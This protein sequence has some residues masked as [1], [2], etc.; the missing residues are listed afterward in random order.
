MERFTK[1]QVYEQKERFE[2]FIQRA[3][4][5]KIGKRYMYFIAND[6]ADGRYTP[7]VYLLRV[8]SI[9]AK[10]NGTML[11]PEKDRHYMDLIEASAIEV[12]WNDVYNIK[13]KP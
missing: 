7:Y 9:I 1:E 10:V 13:V 5:L 2:T 12:F 11:H 3:D 8:L 4:L 6:A